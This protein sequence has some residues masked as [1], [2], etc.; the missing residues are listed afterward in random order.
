MFLLGI[1]ASDFSS[2]H[3]HDRVCVIMTKC[4]FLHKMGPF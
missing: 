2:G 4:H 1:D 3:C